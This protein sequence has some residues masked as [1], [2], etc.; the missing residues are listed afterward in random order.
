MFM[1]KG[2]GRMMRNMTFSGM[3]ST[4]LG[5][6][7]P[8]ADIYETNDSLILYMDVAGVEPE[9]LVVSATLLELT[10]SGERQSPVAEVSCVHQLEIDHG[11]FERTIVLPLPVEVEKI[12]STCKNGFL[13]VTMPKQEAKSKIKIKVD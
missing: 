6:W 11:A 2:L 10:I 13:V 8:L 12:T 3:A 4:F 9:K 7:K 5:A 1:E